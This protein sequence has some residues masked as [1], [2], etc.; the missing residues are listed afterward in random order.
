MISITLCGSFIKDVLNIF[1]T[2]CLFYVINIALL[3]ITYGKNISIILL[4]KHRNTSSVF[5]EMMMKDIQKDV[6]EKL[7]KWA[8]K[9][10]RNKL[11]KETIRNI[12]QNKGFLW[13]VFVRINGRI[14]VRGNRS[15]S[16]FDAWKRYDLF[17]SSPTELFHQ[18]KEIPEGLITL[19]KNF[20]IKN[21]LEKM[22]FKNFLLKVC[23][24][25]RSI[26]SQW[27]AIVN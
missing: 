9:K 5:R 11:M 10:Y 15:S 4:Q 26:W 12:Y 16:I 20:S 8:G 25:E 7:A 24:K 18:T 3:S 27:I 19:S 17:A 23:Q 14:K 13:P 21:L 22:I 2:L 6:A 1:P